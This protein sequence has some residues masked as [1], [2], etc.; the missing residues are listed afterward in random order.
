ML[1]HIEGLAMLWVTIRLTIYDVSGMSDFQTFHPQKSPGR[2]CA[3]K[4]TKNFALSFTV[5]F[6]WDELRHVSASLWIY[7]MLILETKK[8]LCQI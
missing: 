3:T 5:L 6:P 7:G 4:T 8:R 2:L 1:L